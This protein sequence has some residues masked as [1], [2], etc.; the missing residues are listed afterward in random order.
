VR[1][2]SLF[3]AVVALGVVGPLQA[4][5]SLSSLNGS[6]K[7]PSSV[8]PP[9]TVTMAQM[10][11]RLNPNSALIAPVNNSRTFNF[12]KLLPNF[13]FINNRWPLQTGRSQYPAQYLN[14]YGS[15]PK[16]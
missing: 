12:S 10:L 16:N 15:Y 7:M 13:S 5:I 6:S 9:G 3:A 8:A 1:R 2:L 14:P 4:Q 11:P